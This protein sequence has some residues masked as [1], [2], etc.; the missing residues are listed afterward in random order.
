SL[1]VLQRRKP[2]GPCRALTTG[3]ILAVSLSAFSSRAVLCG[4]G[5]A[6]A[7]PYTHY[8]RGRARDECHFRWE[9]PYDGGRLR[10]PHMIEVPFVFDNLDESRL[11]A[12][13][14]TAP[15]LA[16]KVSDA[17]LA[18]ARTGNPSTPKLPAWPP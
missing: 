14:P 1:G 17:W 3:C 6:R 10:S 16:D 5:V 7:G 12:G 2:L 4:L 11:T 8:L 15:A 13:S 9:S 18:F